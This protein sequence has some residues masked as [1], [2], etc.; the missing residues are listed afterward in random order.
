[1][2]QDNSTIR[3]ALIVSAIV[4]VIFSWTLVIAFRIKAQKMRKK[5]LQEESRKTFEELSSLRSD[6]GTLPYKIKDYL[7]SKVDDYDLESF[8]NTFYKNN[9]KTSL[10]DYEQDIF[11]LTAFQ[12]KTKSFAY[13]NSETF[14]IIQWNDLVEKFKDSINYTPRVYNNEKVDLIIV[15]S[16]N[17]SNHEIF[18]KYYS[19]L[20]LNG[21]L[22]IDQKNQSSHDKKIITNH[23]KDQ[24]I[25]FEFSHVKSQFLY[26][27]K[28]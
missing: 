25:V 16:K 14:N 10:I 3:T 26:I 5:I 12:E 6:M 4:F 11:A 28:K 9:Y 13:F 1:M 22:I 2:V 23:L 15:K 18:K 8:I 19:N 21:M 7:K 20:N 27:V 24:N 17:I